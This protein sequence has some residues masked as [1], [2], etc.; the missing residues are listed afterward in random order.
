MKTHCTECR[1]LLTA[2]PMGDG[3]EHVTCPNC[4][5]D[6]G[7]RRERLFIGIYPGGIAYSDRFTEEHGD[8]RRLAF[9]PYDTLTLR[10]YEPTPDGL[11][12][13]IRAHAATITARCGEAF[14][15]DACGHTVRL[16]G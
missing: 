10:I 16:G 4:N 13:E 9:L 14:A 7:E 6:F 3:M 1:T 11:P 5:A 2:A 8:Y 12:A 15:I